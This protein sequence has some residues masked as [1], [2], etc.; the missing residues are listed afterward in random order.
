MFVRADA[1]RGGFQQRAAAAIVAVADDEGDAHARIEGGGRQRRQHGAGPA[2]RRT[3]RRKAAPSGPVGGAYRERRLVVDERAGRVALGRKDVAAAG[4]GLVVARLQAQGLAVLDEGAL[5]VAPLEGG[6]GAARMRPFRA[7]IEP[8]GLVRV[9]KRPLGLA[10]QGMGEGA[11]GEQEGVLRALLDR[12]AVKRDGAHEIGDR[13]GR[14]AARDGR[15]AAGEI[16]VR[17]LRIEPHRLVEIGAGAVVVALEE[18]GA[19]AGVV[20]RRRARRERQGVAVVGDGAL[21]LAEIDAGEAAG[22]EGVGAVAVEPQG[23]VE[24]GDGA[25]VFA[26]RE[27]GEA[28]AVIGPGAARIDQKRAAEI[29]HRAVEIAAGEPDEA[30]VEERVGIVGPAAQD[31]VEILRRALDVAAA[32][33]RG[34]AAGIGVDEVRIETDR[35]VEIGDGA[36]RVA[37]L[38]IGQA[39]AGEGVRRARI[40]GEDLVE[41][42][43]RAVDGAAGEEG[44]APR[45]VGLREAAVE[46]DRL[47]EIG[48][49]AGMV[50][51]PVAQDAAG[52]EGLRELRIDLEGAAVIR[53]GAQKIGLRV[54]GEPADIERLRVGGVE[55]EGAVENRDGALMIARGIGGDAARGDDFCALGGRALGEDAHAGGDLFRSAARG[56]EFARVLGFGERRRREERRRRAADDAK[57]RSPSRRHRQGRSEPVGDESPHAPV[58]IVVAGERGGNPGAGGEAAREDVEAA[59][60]L[61][62]GAVGVAGR[63]VEVVEERPA[64]HRR[65]EDA[66]EHEGIGDLGA[67]AGA[68]DGV[69]DAAM[70]EFG[71]LDQGG[72]AGVGVDDLREGLHEQV[73]EIVGAGEGRAGEARDRGVAARH[74][75]IGDDVRLVDRGEAVAGGNLQRPDVQERDAGADIAGG[76]VRG[77]VA[78]LQAEAA[79]D[80]DIGQPRRQGEVRGDA[81]LGP[82]R[83]LPDAVLGEPAG[84][85]ILLEGQARIGEGADRLDRQERL[86]RQRSVG[87]ALDDGL[88]RRGAREQREGGGGEGRPATGGAAGAGPARSASCRRQAHRRTPLRIVWIVVDGR[89]AVGTD[90][91]CAF[92]VLGAG[93]KTTRGVGVACSW[94]LASGTVVGG[95]CA[96]TFGVGVIGAKVEETSVG[97]PAGGVGTGTGP[98]SPMTVAAGLSERVVAVSA[99]SPATAVR[100]PSP[101][102]IRA[103]VGAQRASGA[104]PARVLPGGEQSGAAAVR[105]RGAAAG[106]ASRACWER[107]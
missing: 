49:G 58:H 101:R 47:A 2:E 59:G 3:G 43:D 21:D 69:E 78:G 53:F 85:R 98:N 11:I 96:T 95:N 68:G 55:G 28:A 106:P 61:E 50:A 82:D 38:R 32:E 41:I 90:A 100:E 93:A 29:R 40:E 36:G 74:R 97:P 56:A 6:E 26:L 73:A 45:L 88:R 17:E 30:A 80:A 57:A 48:D 39:A 18:A 46:P 62:G 66:V 102:P 79:V 75:Q 9:G 4:Q 35:L 77:V 1:S 92:G 91:P 33:M 103:V 16:G 27:E 72:V 20:R 13:K 104:L 52:V 7:R 37:L 76:A 5:E 63:Q 89:T 54:M 25:A 81:D 84:S 107:A 65:D 19:A 8:H 51:A 10:A 24:I 34:A 71:L 105:V 86:S 44:E 22:E 60:D 12:L 64:Q 14:L 99:A 31:R 70:D 83:R 67:D 87:D 94:L 15:L 23:L 42:G